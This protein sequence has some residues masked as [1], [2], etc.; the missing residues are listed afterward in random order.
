MPTPR[1]MRLVA[2]AASVLAFSLSP[3]R[4]FADS[5]TQ[6]NLVS[7]GFVP[8]ATIDSNLVNPWGIAFS[9]TSPFWISDQGTGV[10][11]VYT[12]TGSIVSLV[13]TV[14]G[15]GPPS[16]PTGQVFNTTASFALPSG[17][18]TN[19]IFDTLNGTIAARSTGSTAVTVAT[20]AGAVY[21]GLAL[22][23]VGSNNYLYAANTAG[24]G[25]IQVFDTNYNNVTGST[26]AGTFN[27]P[28]VPAGYVPFNIQLI[29]SQLY[30]TYA[31]LGAG[32]VA[33]PGSTGEVAVFNTNGTFVSLLAS[34]G[35]LDAPW[36]IALAPAGFGSF[37]ND[38]LI[39]NFGSGEIDAYSTTGT[40][41]G[42]LDDNGVPIVDPNLWAL[43][44]RTGGASSTN[45]DA[46]Y[47]TA[48][49]DNQSGGLFGEIVETPE[50]PPFVLVGLGV[51]A[52]ILARFRAQPARRGSA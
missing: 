18:T 13:V 26:F 35:P 16:G 38:L 34:G 46:L 36:G 52:L 6:I 47:F 37:S 3:A 31:E 21:T 1:S 24:S 27:N 10:A 30:V 14:P 12:G 41:E 40:F 7:N 17:G 43:D 11:T 28:F 20:T 9:A 51:L 8:A 45:P 23:S 42:V 19:F 48:G 15:G 4:L 25:S 29:G 49:V 5:F 32:G 22:G 50:P 39:G 2:V 44:F 33:A